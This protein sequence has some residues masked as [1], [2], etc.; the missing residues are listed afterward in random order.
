MCTLVIWHDNGTG[1][2][3]HIGFTEY[4]MNEVHSM[5][6]VDALLHTY[7]SAGVYV[8]SWDV[9]TVVD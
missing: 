1:D 7:N 9:V 6:G 2:H 8:E 5:G 4:S 3:N